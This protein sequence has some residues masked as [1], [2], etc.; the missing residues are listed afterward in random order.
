MPFL[1]MNQRPPK[2]F[3]WKCQIC[4]KKRPDAQI[5]VYSEDTSKAFG[6]KPGTMK[7]NVRYCNDNPVCQEQAPDVLQNIIHKERE[8]FKKD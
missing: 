2:E 7:V 1:K 3:F 5:S 4:G 6:L 8:S